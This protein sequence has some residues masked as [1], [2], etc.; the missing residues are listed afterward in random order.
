MANRDVVVVGASAGGVEALA[1][2]TSI[3][4]VA[5]SA[6]GLNALTHVLSA[7]P[8]DFPAPVVVV[9]HLSREAPSLLADILDRRCAIAVRHAVDGEV[10]KP[11]TVYIAVRDYHLLITASGRLALTH[12][13][14]V[15][16]VRPSA[17]VLFESAA[18]SYGDQ[19]IAVVLTGAG[20]D[21]AAG[22]RA[23]KRAGG[24][25]IAQDKETC[26][27]FGMPAAAIG[28]NGVD[29]VLGLDDIAPALITRVGQLHR[30]S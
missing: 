23:V 3:V 25:V 17:D 11:A 26:E 4:V 12:S 19:V 30:A 16:F 22:V 2:D 14:L 10:P 13:E 21:G 20:V 15:H 18:A 5:T 24:V 9:Q 1:P 27:S 29:E 8:P 28:T 7:L 6:G